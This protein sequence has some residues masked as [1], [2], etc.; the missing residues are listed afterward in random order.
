MIRM[1]W[2]IYNARALHFMIKW[3][4]LKIRDK[5]HNLK[6]EHETCNLPEK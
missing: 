2:D 5:R 3:N 6:S 1:S 4:L